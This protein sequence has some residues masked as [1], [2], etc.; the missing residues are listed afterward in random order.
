LSASIPAGAAI[1]YTAAQVEAAL[2]SPIAANERP[3][4]LVTGANSLLDVQSFLL[5]PGG[6]F[7]NVSSGQAGS[8]IDVRS[9]VPATT[10]GY[11][12]YIRVINTG[13][14]AAPVTVALLDDVTGSVSATATLIASLPANAATTL[15]SSQVEAA[16]GMQIPTAS[17]P[18][19]RISSTADLRVQS[20]L[21]QPGGAFNEISDA[22]SGTSVDVRTYVPAADAGSGYTS[23]LRVINTGITATTVTAALVDGI[24]GA[25][26]S[27]GTLIASLPAGGASTLTS[28]QVEA[29]LGTT[30]VSGSR[31]RIRITG[32]TV[33]EVQSFLTQPG[34]AF[35]E[36]SGGQSSSLSGSLPVFSVAT[37]TDPLAKQQWGLL[38]TGQ[39]GYA[40]TAGVANTGGTL[41]TDINADPVYST[42]GYTGK[43]VIVAVVDT[44]LE[45]L[46]EDL[47]ANVVPGGSWNFINSSTDPTS[48]ATTGD[49]GTMVSGLIA[50]AMNG[51]GGIGVAPNAQLKGFNLLS[52]S[53]TYIS[54]YVTSLGGS[55]ASP[56]SSDVF[57]FNQSYGTDSTTDSQENA[58]VEA[59]YAS[60]TSTLRGGKGALYVKSAGNGFTGFGSG[61]A[62]AY[63]GTAANPANGGATIIG[64]SCQNANFDPDNTLPYNI[65][66]AALNAKG[67]KASYSTAGSAI[68]ASAPGGEYGFNSAAAAA[69]GVSFPSQSY[70]PAMVT[71]DQ[72]G[73]A[74]GESMNP[75]TPG[76]NGSGPYSYFNQGGAANVGGINL[77]CNYTNGMSGTSSAAPM[78]SGSIA[79][80]L[81]ANP[82]LTWREVKDILAKTAVKVDAANPSVTV[83]TLTGG[84]YV[85]EQGWITNAAGLNFHNWY[86]FGAVNVSA[87]VAMAKTYTSGSLGTFTNTGW[88]SSG[89]LSLTVPDN[90]VTGVT[91]T[92][93]VPKVGAGIVEAVQIQVTTT[94]A[95]GTAATGCTTSSDG[96]TGDIAIELTSPL[97]TKS[98]LKNI[99][100]GFNSLLKFSIAAEKQ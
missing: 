62:A 69:L 61:T 28:S 7:T 35:T 31:P 14:I 77:N 46:H 96:C 50:M 52:S 2:G 36:V 1:T 41:G 72:S 54:Y 34:G 58:T 88:I 75:P 40:D 86:G 56:N 74:I 18:R 13:A 76:V 16:L 23:Y 38:N 15:L 27:A 17:R 81:E 93:A 87:A 83:T 10:T 78:M 32:S 25:A 71:T 98:I 19:I 37:V 42:Y 4:I 5:Q 9:Y 95:K 53:P 55:T 89:A 80:I 66:M 49:H 12:S 84:S 64:V 3:R 44:G 99:Q 39:N 26:G 85:A 57:I 91:T 51:K 30:I 20:F 24:T 47:K 45:I 92:L 65:V 67:K 97:G 22:S 68:W 73:C 60:G 8:T 48:T 79:L 94:A 70:D 82:A 11:T 90:S 59:Q 21:L 100:D 33:L 6:A 63:C 43:G 29:A